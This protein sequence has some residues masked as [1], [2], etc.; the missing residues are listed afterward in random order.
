MRNSNISTRNADVALSK[1]IAHAL[2]HGPA[3]YG[4]E[5]DEQGW[6]S[7]DTLLAGLRHRGRPTLTRED[8]ERVVFEQTN[9]IRY[10][11]DESRQRIRATHGHSNGNEAVGKV[12]TIEYEPSSPPPILFHGTTDKAADNIFETGFLSPMRRQYVHLSSDRT[13]AEQAGHRKTSWPVMLEI[14]AQQAAEEAGI[15]FYQP[16]EDAPIWLAEKIPA[17]YINRCVTAD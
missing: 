4:L 9:K 3:L 5:L 6:T 17:K 2:R 7:V 13:I 10:E 11:F 14:L 1:S 16:V 12:P 15:R 8:I